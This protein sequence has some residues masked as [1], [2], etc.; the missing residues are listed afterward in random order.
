MITVISSVN[1]HIGK[2]KGF[3]WEMIGADQDRAKLHGEIK[4]TVNQRFLLSKQY[5]QLL[6]KTYFPAL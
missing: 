5:L 6:L 4:Q 3:D 2:H 1:T